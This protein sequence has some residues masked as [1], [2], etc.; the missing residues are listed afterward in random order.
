[1]LG[2]DEAVDGETALRAATVD[3]AWV[4]GDEDVRGR[5]APGFLADLVLLGADPTRT[6]PDL[7]GDIEVVATFCDGVP[8]HGADALTWS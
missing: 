6:D 1:V 5:L 4:A 2:A 7:L 3:A 8:T